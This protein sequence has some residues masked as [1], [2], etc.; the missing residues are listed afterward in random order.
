MQIKD[1]EKRI[2]KDL[3]E[4]LRFDER[5]TSGQTMVGGTVVEINIVEIDEDETKTLIWS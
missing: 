1:D 3:L 5:K 2:K 4:S